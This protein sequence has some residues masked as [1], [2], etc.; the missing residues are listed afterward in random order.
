MNSH[1]NHVSENADDAI[2]ELLAVADQDTFEPG[3]AV[4]DRVRSSLSTAIDSHASNILQLPASLK[5]ADELSQRTST[6]NGVKV[7]QSNFRRLRRWTMACALLVCLAL[8]SVSLLR[9]PKVLGQVFS[10]LR[11]QPRVHVRCKDV[12]GNDIEA[13]ISADRYAVKRP[14][15]S[16]LLHRTKQ[17]VDTWY[18]TKQRIVRSVPSFSHAAPEFGSLLELLN[19][20]PGSMSEVGGMKVQSMKAEPGKR[21][22]SNIMRH[23]M[24]LA[25]GPSLTNGDITMSLD[26]IVDVSTNLPSECTATIRQSGV[27][28]IHERTVTMTFDYPHDEPQTI[29]DLGAAET[30]T[31]VDTT[32]PESD[33]LYAKVQ[34]AMERGRRGLKKYRALAGTDPK[35]PHWVIWRSGNRWRVDYTGVSKALG[36]ISEEPGMTPPDVDVTHWQNQFASGSQ[37]TDIFDGQDRWVRI[38]PVQMQ[39]LPLPPFA[40]Q[41]LRD[42]A[43]I[44]S[45][46][47]ERQAYP[48]LGEEDGFVLTIT[49]ESPGGLV[50]AEYS[51]VAKMED[52]IH[53]TRRYWLDPDH[54]YA[55]VKSEYTDATGSEEAFNA[56]H[57]SRKHMVTLNAGF[58]Q[59]TGGIWY[60]T[61]IRDIG[62]QAWLTLDEPVLDDD[63]M[64]YHVD[65]SSD[66]PE[67]LFEASK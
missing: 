66:V 16:F 40:P 22:D 4:I 43:W 52:L 60:P 57:G 28:E 46:T 45:M 5:D 50:L 39:K 36:R 42:S 38:S 48:L 34:S 32:N 23:S 12:Q 29:H 56:T 11:S 9:P 3:Q 54:G 37:P 10:A 49:E 8:T 55:V 31:L 1:L 13:W 53:R 58:E 63:W 65:F 25:T 35:S 64:C 17:T 62:K 30:A 20:I 2:R 59:S 41:Q 24:E 33:P 19:S 26:V 21:G 44:G 15:S 6:I 47:L 14:E 51:A 27:G 7:R 61:R 67:S 18:P